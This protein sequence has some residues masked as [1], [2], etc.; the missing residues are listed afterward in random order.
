[1]ELLARAESGVDDLHRPGGLGTPILRRTLNPGHNTGFSGSDESLGIALVVPI[2]PI[3]E[4]I[5]KVGATF[6]LPS[7]DSRQC[8]DTGQLPR[9]IRWQA[10]RHSLLRVARGDPTAASGEHEH[11]AE[12]E[13]DGPDARHS[14]DVGPGER[15]PTAG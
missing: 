9:S 13:G 2:R 12:S 5:G 14:R 4:V 10:A 6:T 3:E 8:P 1:V 7:D 15:Q 11:S